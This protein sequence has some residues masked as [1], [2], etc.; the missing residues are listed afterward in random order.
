MFKYVAN[1]HGNEVV[2]RQLLIYLAQYLAN[3]YGKDRRITRLLNRTE[4]FLLPS[5]NPDGFARSQEGQCDN[6]TLGRRTSQD[7]DLNRDFPKRVEAA[8]KY[9]DLRKGRAPET[10]LIMDWIT[11]QPFVLSANLHA[12]AVVASYPLDDGPGHRMSGYY[13]ASADDTTFR[14]LAKTYSRKHKT[15]HKGVQCADD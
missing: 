11:S 15:M 3:N 1:M 5:L 7:V 4:I 12:G 14:F 9:S 8:K 6:N 10:L 2:G 13:S